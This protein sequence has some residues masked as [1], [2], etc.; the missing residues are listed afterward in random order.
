VA[1]PS[2]L[3]FVEHMHEFVNMVSVG[4]VHEQVVATALDLRPPA[5]HVLNPSR[6]VRVNLRKH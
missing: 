2:V 6:S 1:L 4:Q 3:A 5:S